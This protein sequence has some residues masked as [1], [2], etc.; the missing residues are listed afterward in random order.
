MG[1][2][3]QVCIVREVPSV[4]CRCQSGLQCRY[5][6]V[7]AFDLLTLEELNLVLIHSFPSE[8]NSCLGIFIGLHAI[9][10]RAPFRKCYFGGGQ[11]GFIMRANNK[12]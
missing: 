11:L 1:Q 6:K 3:M 9:F 4:V 8:I 5:I 2:V 12:F 10:L 7:D